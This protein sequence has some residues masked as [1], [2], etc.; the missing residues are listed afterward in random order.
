MGIVVLYDM[1]WMKRGKGYNLFIGYGVLM[2][3][4]IGKV[5]FYVMRCK[6]CRVCEFSKKLGKVVKIYD[7]R[8]NYGGFFKF[9]ERDV[10][11]EFWINVFDSGI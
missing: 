9:M 3:L 5:L 6:V 7:C 4:K 10:V 2:G 11:V 8:K 1:G